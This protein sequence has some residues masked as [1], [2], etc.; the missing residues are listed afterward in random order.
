MSET[1]TKLTA[2]NERLRAEKDTI[3]LRLSRITHDFKNTFLSWQM[4][5]DALDAGA[6]TEQEF[7][8]FLPQIKQDCAKGLSIIADNSA[9]AKTQFS[10][11]KPAYAD[12]KIA[13]LLTKVEAD[14]RKS[15]D[16]KNLR[17]TVENLGA[18]EICTDSS[19]LSFVLNAVLDNAVKYSYAGGEISLRYGSKAGNH[20]FT[21][22]D[23]GTGMTSEQ[24]RDVFSFDAALFAG[25]AG[26]MGPGFGLKTARDFAKLLEGDIKIESAP[27]LGTSVAIVLPQK[28]K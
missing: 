3:L 13:D 9:W 27:D 4:L 25:T 12:V 15:L 24:L 28:E 7:I 19:L 20:V 11:Y 26:E 21:V 18:A 8:G 10:G 6:V 16:N 23:K 2:E 5:M 14:L 1:I 17:L 22:E